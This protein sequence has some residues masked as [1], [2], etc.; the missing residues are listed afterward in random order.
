MLKGRALGGPGQENRGLEGLG[1]LLNSVPFQ[2]YECAMWALRIER[3]NLVAVHSLDL[4]GLATYPTEAHQRSGLPVAGK[5]AHQVCGYDELDIDLLSL[6]DT[7]KRWWAQFRGLTL[8]GRPKGIGTWVTREQFVADL[9]RAVTTTRFDGKNVTQ[10]NIALRLNTGS[11]Q[12]RRWL[13]HFE[14]NWEEIRKL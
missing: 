12:L 1:E 8:R 9:E 7:A 11:R 5:L 4:F 6:L 2:E 14:I 13:Q 10:E 3:R